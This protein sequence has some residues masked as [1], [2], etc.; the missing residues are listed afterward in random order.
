MINFMV[1]LHILY[2][3]VYISM[4]TQ[5]RLKKG[6]DKIVEEIRTEGRKEES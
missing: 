2:D 6:K 5:I 3:S 4:E 1:F